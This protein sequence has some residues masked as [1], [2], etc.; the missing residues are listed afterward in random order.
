M[1]RIEFVKSIDNMVAED[2][3]NKFDELMAL[4]NL[5]GEYN[6]IKIKQTSSDVA[7]FSIDF[8][9]EDSANTFVNRINNS[10]LPIYE[11]L[12]SIQCILNKQ[13]VNIT[14]LRV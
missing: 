9:D 3:F 1:D 6:N 13:S 4:Y 7:S 12:L 11:I 2:I 5:I 14:L 8:N 10:V